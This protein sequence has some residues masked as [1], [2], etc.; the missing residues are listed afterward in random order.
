MA[1]DAF[2]RF[3]KSTTSMSDVN[4]ES[5]DPMFKSFFELKDFSFGVEN[6]TVIGSTT[7]GAG[8]GK[9][10]FNEFTIRKTADAASPFF[11]KN[12]AAGMHYK[13]VTLAMR[14]AGGET[15]GAGAPFLVFSFGTVFCT[16]IDWAGPG[17]EGPEESITF[18]YGQL[19]VAHAKQK[20]D[21]S[22]EPL[23]YTSWNMVTNKGEFAIGVTPVRTFG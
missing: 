5:M 8:G 11:F 2:I 18:A 6:V 10:Q 16:K 23:K 14:K 12:C 22:M 20:S 1:V 21:G 19:D 7:S 4:G 15:S 9:I 13:L 3:E 17:D